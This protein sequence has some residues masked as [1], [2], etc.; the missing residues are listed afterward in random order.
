MDVLYDYINNEMREFQER[1][2]GHSLK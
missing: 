2:S 1:D